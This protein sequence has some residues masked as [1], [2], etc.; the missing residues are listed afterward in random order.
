MKIVNLVP[1]VHQEKGKEFCVFS[2]NRKNYLFTVYNCFLV[3]EE[4]ILFFLFNYFLVAYPFVSSW[5]CL[6]ISQSIQESI[7]Y[8]RE[9]S[10]VC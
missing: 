4:T 5:S 2:E 8:R 6:H 7:P 9:F 1:F 10:K 3:I